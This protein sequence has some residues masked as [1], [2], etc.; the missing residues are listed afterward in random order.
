MDPADIT[1]NIL[2]YTAGFADYLC[3]RAAH[4]EQTSGVKESILHLLQFVEMGIPILAAMFLEI[5]A[6]VILV[7]IVFFFFHEVTAL[8]DLS[9][10][11][12]TRKVGPIEQP[13]HS[14]L[15]MLPLMGLLMIIV[16]YWPQF[17]SLLGFTTTNFELRLKQLPLPWT[18][19]A[20]ML[21]WS[22]YSR[23]C[24]ILRNWY[25]PPVHAEKHRR[26]T[27]VSRQSEK[28]GL[29]PAPVRKFGE[30]RREHLSAS[31]EELS[32]LSCVPWKVQWRSLVCGFSPCLPCRRARS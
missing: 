19:V 8:L 20:T 6:L 3:H 29:A 18:Y 28:V 10:A 11:S 1:R 12:A 27:L 30:L 13:V 31:F 9:Y 4:I 22:S 32:S 5:N 14:F 23:F 17:V 25:A 16:L 2:M 26:A 21:T 15:E 24:R 7:M